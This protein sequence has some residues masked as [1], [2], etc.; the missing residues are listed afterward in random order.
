LNRLSQT[1]PQPHQFPGIAGIA[2]VIGTYLPR[3][4][5]SNDMPG[6]ARNGSNA[7]RSTRT[8][9]EELCPYSEKATF[10][11]IHFANGL[12]QIAPALQQ[13]RSRWDEGAQ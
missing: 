1:D 13:R 6:N 12:F 2:T 5:S 3:R 11:N 7:L 4:S 8:G 9:P 10:A